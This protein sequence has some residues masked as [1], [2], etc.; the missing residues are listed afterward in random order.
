MKGIFL[1]GILKS[2]KM[3]TFDVLFVPLAKQGSV[4]LQASSFVFSHYFQSPLTQKSRKECSQ[5]I[6]VIALL[7]ISMVANT[8]GESLVF[9]PFLHSYGIRKATPTHLFMFFGLQTFFDDPQGLATARLKSW[10]DPKTEKDDDEVVVYGVNS[11]RSEIIYNKSM[12]ALARY[13][14]KGS[15]KDQFLAPKGIAADENGHVY[16]ADSGNNRI[17]RLFNPKSNLTWKGAF[18]GASARYPGI[19]GPSR[20][21]IDEQVN[22]YVTDPGNRRLVVFDSTGTVL[23]TIPVAGSAWKF[24][25][26]PTALAVADGS[27]PWS[28]FSGEKMLFCADKNGT[29]VWK[30]GFDGTL[31]ALGDLPAGH[32]ASYGAIDYFHNYWVTDTKAHCVLKLDHNL[33]LLDIFGS[34][35]DGDNQFI[36]PRG[37][38]IYKRYGQTFIAEKKGAQYFWVGTELKK[39][40]LVKDDENFYSIFMRTTEYSFAT[41]FSAVGGDTI[42]YFKGRWI[43][44][45]SSIVKFNVKGAEGIRERGL[46]LRIEPTYSSRTYNSW[47]Y[48]I[49]VEKNAK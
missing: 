17:V 2:I 26:G 46:T 18:N 8:L 13:G 20:V 32:T 21:G 34:Y 6:A 19:R 4:F 43:P 28:H 5:A 45:D 44:C 35:G 39:A 3:Y 7:V 12:L 30:I 48:P 1:G 31:H 16:V 33:R 9:P 37:I 49:K 40:S 23:R 15:G 25:N 27:A 24:I 22:V 38:A 11:G 42:I 47:H 36:E 14:K 10:D 29:R 41:L